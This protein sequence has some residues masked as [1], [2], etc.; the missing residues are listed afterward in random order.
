MKL[1][2]QIEQARF[3]QSL[4]QLRSLQFKLRRLELSILRF[5][6]VIPGQP[7]ARDQ[8]IDQIIPL[9]RAAQRLFD[10]RKSEHRV[11]RVSGRKSAAQE[12]IRQEANEKKHGGDQKA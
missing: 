3:S 11:A 4:L 12:R 5:T 2:F 7:T 10:T 8:P 9:K 1:R 6:V